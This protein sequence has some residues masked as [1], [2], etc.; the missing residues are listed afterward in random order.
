MK[1]TES[2]RRPSKN[3]ILSLLVIGGIL[4][5]AFWGLR[6]WQIRYSNPII[7]M[8]PTKLDRITLRNPQSDLTDEM[9]PQLWSSVIDYFRSSTPVMKRPESESLAEVMFYE[10]GSDPIRVE[11]LNSGRE[12]GYFQVNGVTF[13][14]GDERFFV[15]MMDDANRRRERNLNSPPQR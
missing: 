8:N 2:L 5:T 9:D 6:Y 10:T 11:V 14:G 3:K 15:R 13:R 12:V 7:G 1:T 4:A